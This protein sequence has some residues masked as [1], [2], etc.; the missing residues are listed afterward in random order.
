VIA[1]R[2]WSVVLCAGILAGAASAA[3]QDRRAPGSGTRLPVDAVDS[4]RL[5]RLEQWI[6][7]VAR[8]VPGE[9]DAALVEIAGW[10]NANLKQLF[11]DASALM[12]TIAR[13]GFGEATATLS[14]RSAEQKASVQVRYSK[15]QFYRLQVLACA[16]GG[17][18]FER[19]CML[20]KAGDQLDP[21]LRQLAALV[22]ASNRR[23]DHNYL[24]RHAALVH[25]DVGMLAP[26]AMV[27]PGEVTRPSG[28][29]VERFRMEISDGQE[30]NLRQSAVHWEIARMLLDF[31][32]PR[33]SDHA[34]PG[35]DD[36][37][38][39]WYV[40]T[41]A[42]MQ[43][44]E[45]HDK[46]HLNRAR[47]L[48]PSDPDV[49]FLSA[50][51]RETYAGPPI[52]A[53]VK[54][55]TLPTGVTLD[56]TSDRIELRE[57]EGLFRRTLQIKSNFPEARLRFGR[58]LYLLGK[59]AEAAAELRQAIGALVDRQMLYYAGMFLGAAEE[60]LGNRDAARVAYEQSSELYPLAQS[61]LLAL[62]QLARRAGD[63][64]GALRAIERLFVIP[65]D[66]RDEKTDPW[67][68]YY[69]SQGRDAELLLDAMQQ[70]FRS[71]V[72]Q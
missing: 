26:A 43:L 21:E 37:V 71:E 72:L 45:D 46:L 36:M 23:G 35:H 28:T 20:L 62:S 14:V 8:H 52:Q 15:E 22:S 2:S 56:V 66:D 19:G 41:A 33:G 30:L 4:H 40:A 34:N 67:W 58:V 32:R 17:L 51:Q 29:A 60:S 61:P 27:A 64:L 44:K 48:F 50:C 65:A 16:A 7:A 3:S 13:V 70:P 5:E 1:R 53:A 18:V 55:A 11:L 24:V 49:F 63:R 68:W 42:W 12:Q 57:A 59:H 6:K 39:Q 31:V 47:E 38:R 54:S 25:S 10:P 69:V 9:E